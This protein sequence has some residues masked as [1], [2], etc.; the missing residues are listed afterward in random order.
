MKVLHKKLVSVLLI[1]LMLIVGAVTVSRYNGSH[2]SSGEEASSTE[3]VQEQTAGASQKETDDALDA[4]YQSAATD[5]VFWYEDDSYGDYFETAAIQYFGRTGKKVVMQ[6]RDTMDYIGDIYDET[7]QDGAYPDVY[8]ISG[9]DLEEAYLYGLVSVNEIDAD[10]LPVLEQAKRAATY[11]DKLLGY[12]LSYDVCVFIYQNGYFE[13]EPQS[14]QSIIDYSNDN[15][16]G[17]DVEYLL[18]WNV[19][20]AFFD[21]PFVSNSISFEKSELGHTDVTYDEDLYAQD[22]EYFE[23]ILE[24]FSVNAETVSE[25]EILGNFL[26]GRTLCAIVDSDMLHELDGYDYS[27]MQ[28]PD[29]NDELAA[30]TCALTDMIVVNDYSKNQKVA[31]DFARFVTGDMADELYDMTGHM[32]VVSQ[33]TGSVA[34]QVARAAY[35]NSVLAPD[36]QDAKDFWVKLEETISKYF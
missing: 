3:S 28:I 7:M 11:E 23:Q 30:S 18:E 36:S 14:L 29:L 2:T 13:E 24:S 31:A 15:E 22:L 9:Q 10:D 16:P 20:D 33:D 21:F 5:A 6:C 26:T 4:A 27:L 19:N 34:E 25:E 17:E 1:C 35:E 12:P 32:S 8:L